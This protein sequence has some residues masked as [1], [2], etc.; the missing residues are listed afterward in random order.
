MADVTFPSVP[1]VVSLLQYDD[2][3]RS[4]DAR[5]VTGYPVVCVTVG[6]CHLRQNQCIVLQSVTH[7]SFYNPDKRFPPQ[8][9]YF[10]LKVNSLLHQI[11]IP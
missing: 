8:F 10:L 1:V 5:L 9:F 4:R 3:S 2:P 6:H 7:M 11:S